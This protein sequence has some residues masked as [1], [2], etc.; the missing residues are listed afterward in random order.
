MPEIREENEAIA[1][2]PSNKAV[3]KL[4]EPEEQDSYIS[5]GNKAYESSIYL[6]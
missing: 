4:M 2:T 1:A 6:L 5:N 3:P